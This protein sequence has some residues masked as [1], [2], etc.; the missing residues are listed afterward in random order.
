[1]AKNEQIKEESQQIKEKKSAPEKF[2][3][4]CRL[5]WGFYAL[6]YW[7]KKVVARKKDKTLSEWSIR[8]DFP[9]FLRPRTLFL[10]PYV[11]LKG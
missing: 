9:I 5:F 2:L 6:D 4:Q 10:Q 7:C 8:N 3:F 1:M 11:R